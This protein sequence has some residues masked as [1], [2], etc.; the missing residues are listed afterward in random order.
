[1]CFPKTPKTRK[2]PRPAP[3]LKAPEPVAQ[4]LAT[5]KSVKAGRNRASLGVSQLRTSLRAASGLNLPK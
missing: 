4:E 5:P 1:M 2:A 3:P